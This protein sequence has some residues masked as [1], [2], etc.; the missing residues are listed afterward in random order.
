[1]L[2]SSTLKT[3]HIRC[4]VLLPYDYWAHFSVIIPH[5]GHL[6]RVFICDVR[7]S[8]SYLP[9]D[10]FRPYH[11]NIRNL[12]VHRGKRTDKWELTFLALSPRIT[13]PGEK[14]E[15]RTRCR[16]SWCGV[17][18]ERDAPL[19]PDKTIIVAESIFPSRIGH[20]PGTITKARFFPR[21]PYT[22]K[23]LVCLLWYDRIWNL[24]CLEEFTRVGRGH[25]FLMVERTGLSS[26][27][28]SAGNSRDTYAHIFRQAK[29]VRATT[30][31]ID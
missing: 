16:W 3:P 29:Q 14:E 7:P 26:A 2:L 31:N 1:M 5:N 17:A 9:R 28:G 10:H 4:E 24:I 20:A 6:I 19:C 18:Q 15:L 30:L 22:T 11:D 12:P 21:L 13:S 25:C 23:L 27:T 8:R